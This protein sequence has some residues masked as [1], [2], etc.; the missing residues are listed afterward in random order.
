V[1]LDNHL[2]A[3]VNQRASQLSDLKIKEDG[4]CFYYWCCCG[5]GAG[6]D[7]FSCGDGEDTVTDY[8]E[9]EGDIAT[10]DCENTVLSSTFFH[11][12]IFFFYFCL[13]PNVI[14]TLAFQSL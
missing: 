14:Q 5:A 1:R 11:S 8:N 3:Q 7:V 12:F 10:P 6:A 13:P 9:A 2:K 4:S